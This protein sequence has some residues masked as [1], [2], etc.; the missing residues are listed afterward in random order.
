MGWRA[1]KSTNYCVEFSIKRK[2]INERL[3]MFFL[4][5][6]NWCNVR[7]SMQKHWMQ[8]HPLHPRCWVSPGSESQCKF[9]CK[10]R[11]LQLSHRA[12]FATTT[13]T[14]RKLWHRQHQGHTSFSQ[15]QEKRT[16]SAS[17]TMHLCT[18]YY[19]NTVFKKA[20]YAF[21]GQLNNKQCVF[22]I[23]LNCI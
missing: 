7:V 19:N 6:R 21:D 10:S 16:S 17:I 2:I 8:I 14:T 13:K 4:I 12:A 5:L 1:K 23:S 9:L 18:S 22:C 11:I 15:Q 3:S 20:I